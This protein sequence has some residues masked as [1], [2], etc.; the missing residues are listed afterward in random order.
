MTTNNPFQSFNQHNPFQGANVSG[1]RL[2][3]SLTDKRLFGVCGGIAKHFDIDPTLVRLGF[4]AFALAGGAAIPVYVVAALIMP[5]EPATAASTPPG[6][7]TA[8]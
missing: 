5:E 1:I 7:P 4:A 2:T 8:V 3:R 6:F